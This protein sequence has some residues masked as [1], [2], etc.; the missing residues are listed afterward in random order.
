MICYADGTLVLARGI[1]WEEAT[2]TANT[3][4]ACAISS[5]WKLDLRVASQKT[6]CMFVYDRSARVPP[7]SSIMIE[8]ARVEVTPG[9]KYLGLHQDGQWDFTSH[10]ERLGPKLGRVAAALCSL[11][12]NIGGPDNRVRRLY[13]NAVS[14][15]VL[16][17]AP[18]WAGE[19]RAKRRIVAIL[20]GAQRLMATRLI[21]AYRTVLHAAVTALAGIIPAELLARLYA[22]TY[23][24][25]AELRRREDDHLLTARDVQRIRDSARR[26]A[27]WRWQRSLEALNTPGIRTIAITLRDI[28]GP[29]LLQW[30]GRAHG[31]LSYH[32][33]QVLTGHGCFGRYLCRIGKERTA[34]CRHCAA[35]EDSAKHMLQECPAWTQ[36]RGVLTTM[37]GQDLRLPSIVPKML[38]SREA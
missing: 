32:M 16:Y 6:E 9:I 23:N 34:Q 4:V 36:E 33:T 25:V 37:V 11:L 14:S 3:A 13:S 21:K 20:H 19:T 30:V 26:G 38:E 1:D 10:F 12:A 18:V 27:L 24:R 35:S 7:R 31:G 22:K 15:Y 2:A 17:G 28:V 8:S 5:I 29:C